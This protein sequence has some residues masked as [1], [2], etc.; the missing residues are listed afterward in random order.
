MSAF[1]RA[2]RD[3][4]G[5]THRPGV[6]RTARGPPTEKA[7]VASNA[8]L[9]GLTSQTGSAPKEGTSQR[10]DNPRRLPGGADRDKPKPQAT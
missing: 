7:R 1:E 6:R 3:V 4:A 5:P 2:P 8:G 10:R 9:S